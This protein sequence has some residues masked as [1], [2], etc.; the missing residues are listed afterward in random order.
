MPLLPKM[1]AIG[2]G[3]TNAVVWIAI[4]TKMGDNRQSIDRKRL[5][6]LASGDEA[7]DKLEAISA[8]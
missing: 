8:D 1:V 2:I 4:P 6:M 3:A 7:S 5:E